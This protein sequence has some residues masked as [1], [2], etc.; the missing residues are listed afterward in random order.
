VHTTTGWRK[1]LTGLL[2]LAALAAAFIPGVLGANKI[3]QARG[4][5]LPSQPEMVTGWWLL[6]I[7]L[8]LVIVLLTFGFRRWRARPPLAE[9]GPGGLDV[10]RPTPAPPAAGLPAR[11]GRP[12][13]A[14]RPRPA[15]R[16]V[17]ILMLGFSGSGK[18]VMLAALHRYFSEKNAIRLKA[19]DEPTRRLAVLAQQ[20][21]DT[22][23]NKELP[24]GQAAFPDG[25]S[26][27]TL[28]EFEVLAADGDQEATAFTL[29]YWDYAGGDVEFLLDAELPAG[30]RRDLADALRRA[31]VVMGV[32]D[33]AELAQL[34]AGRVS[35]RFP[36]Q[37]DLLIDLLSQ[38]SH[39]SVHLVISKADLLTDGNGCR[40]GLSEV[41]SRLDR[42][43]HRF[44]DFRS[45]ARRSG[46]R[47]IGVAAL[48]TDGYAYPQDAAAGIMLKREDR[49]WNPAGV[50]TLLYC[51]VSDVIS[52]DLLTTGSSG[53][54][55]SRLTHGVLE[56]LQGIDIEVSLPPFTISLTDRVRPVLELLIRWLDGEA[57]RLGPREALRRVVKACATQAASLGRESWPYE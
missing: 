18:T 45:S 56:L 55:V 52:H 26:T 38:A 25:T 31:D 17:S 24:S 41:L 36:R 4:E 13:G 27:T 22:R 2:Y 3:S 20:I 8:L 37:L 19:A 29:E 51:A 53:R 43:Y 5:P 9:P 39:R 28:W 47:V 57:T 16:T 44:A 46:M 49:P 14:E 40:Y 10:P 6:G 48:G 35:P 42:V 32:L 50:Q 15:E 30:S 11:A 33:G 12:A 1:L 34:M 23:P 21:L 7:S 54:R